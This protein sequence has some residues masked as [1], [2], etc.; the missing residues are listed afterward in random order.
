MNEAAKQ[1]GEWVAVTPDRV[2]L[3]VVLLVVLIYLVRRTEKQSQALKELHEKS[4]ARG[5]KVIG[6]VERN[7]TLF[8]RLMKRM[9]ES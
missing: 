7:T 5:E 8:E 6:V 1:A 3:I 2:V 9:E 4:E